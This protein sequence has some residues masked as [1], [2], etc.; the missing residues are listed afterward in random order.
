M[1]LDASHQFGAA[2]IRDPH[3]ECGEVDDSE[4]RDCGSDAA[5]NMTDVEQRVLCGGAC[6]R[7]IRTLLSTIL[8][9]EKSSSHRFRI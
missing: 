2:P 6:L 4:P 1:V 3:Q 9:V 7:W 8:V 5:D